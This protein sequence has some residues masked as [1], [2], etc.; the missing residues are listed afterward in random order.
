MDFDHAG[1]VINQ[2]DIS[3]ESNE[4]VIP[5]QFEEQQ[6]LMDTGNEE[7]IGKCYLTKY[8]YLLFNV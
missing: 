1:V 7:I 4:G 5:I 6:M 3:L 8:F 2:G